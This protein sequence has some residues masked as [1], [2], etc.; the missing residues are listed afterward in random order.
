MSFSS[1]QSSPPPAALP[2]G[3]GTI[4]TDFE[5]VI[6]RSVVVAAVLDVVPHAVDA[7]Q[8]LVARISSP[9]AMMSGGHPQ[10]NPQLA[11]SIHEEAREGSSSALP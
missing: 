2:G 6:G 9:F 3:P 11:Q 8:E 1:A 10:L 4:P 5:V 7:L